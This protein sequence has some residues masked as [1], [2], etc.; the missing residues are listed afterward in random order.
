MSLPLPFLPPDIQGVIFDMDG[1]L[2]D[3]ERVALATVAEAAAQLGVPWRYDVGLALVGLN[4][5]D[6][7]AVIRQHLGED[8]PTTELYETFGR[9]YEVAIVEGRIP[10]KAGVIELFEVLD[11]LG[12]PRVVA[13]STRRSRAEPKLA[14]VGLLTRLHGMVCGDEVSLGKPAP[15][16]FLA[17]AGRLGVPAANCLVLEDSNAGV[18]GALAAGARVVMVP[19]LLEP[20]ADVRAAGVPRLASLHEA[21]SFLRPDRS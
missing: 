15:D 17:A 3:S 9:L 14:A 2:L 1:L 4:S 21:A 19:D 7:P 8:Y 11:A 6:G 16:I 5:R 13:T 10:L 12:T 18:R 20:A